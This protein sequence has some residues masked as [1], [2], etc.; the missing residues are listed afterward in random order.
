MFGI[1][2]EVEDTQSAGGDTVE[3][4][5][6]DNQVTINEGGADPEVIIDS[7]PV[8]IIDSQPVETNRQVINSNQ[9]VK[10]QTQEKRIQESA[11]GKKPVNRYG[12]WTTYSTVK[13]EI[14][15]DNQDDIHFEAMALQTFVK[16]N[17]VVP[18]SF[19]TEKNST[20]WPLWQKAIFA[21]LDR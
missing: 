21:E 19:K 14:L 3:A 6:Q 5:V 9:P 16:E 20:K 7:Q 18:N 15:K 2:L 10:T 12:N 4:Q 1:K 17:A 8:V 11:R 13:Q